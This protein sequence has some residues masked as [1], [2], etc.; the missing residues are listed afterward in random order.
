MSKHTIGVVHYLLGST[1]GVSLEDEKWI[2]IMKSM[3]HR[4]VRIAGD[5]NG[6]PG[7]EIS[8][9]Y[10][11][12]D[13][14]HRFFKNTM[15]E[16]VDY[17]SDAA[18]RK[19]I[20]E[21]ADRIEADLTKVIKEEGIDILMPNNVLTL[22]YNP[23]TTIAVTNVI[24]KMDLTVISHNHDFY[25]DRIDNY[26]F[27]SKTAVEI[28]DLYMP[29]QLPKVVHAVINS[30]SQKR[31]MM[32]KGISST[33]VPNVFDFGEEWTSDDYNADFREA[34]GLRKDDVYI[35]QATRVI[36]RKGI[37][38]ALD[39]VAALNTPER[40][41]VLEEKGLYNGKK[42]TKDSRIVFVLAG[43]TRDDQS[44]YYTQALKD[45]IADLGIDALFIEDH[46]AGDRGRG[47]N[48]EKLYSLWDAY[49]QA[50]F[51]TYPSIWEGWG[52]QLLEAIKAK[53][54]T[55]IFEYP[56]YK[57]DLASSGLKMISVGDEMTLSEETRLVEA[58][59]KNIDRAADEA[60]AILTNSEAYEFMVDHNFNVGRENFSLTTLRA[61]IKMLISNAEML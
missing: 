24:R 51:I 21:V 12:T 13:D 15:Y 54:A 56:V 28:A 31:L 43:F 25:W 8:E 7:R 35:L 38:M 10:H 50:D 61:Y 2:E 53:T 23:A 44:G 49:D 46:I 3:G 37:G 60:L 30:Y 41:K 32:R 39:F 4:V 29:P 16:M 34:V 1:D 57:T 45:R 9:M 20:F 52:N 14:A 40:R 59:Q 18:L 19:D 36:P 42:F 47:E 58:P 6:R 48:G 5:L 55:M 22:F 27:P 26:C 33:I 17:D 11:H